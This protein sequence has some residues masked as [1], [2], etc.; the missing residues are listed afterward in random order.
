MT[1]RLRVGNHPL[2]S[3]RNGPWQPAS[4][5]GKRR[6]RQHDRWLWRK[7]SAYLETSSPL[8]VFEN[9]AGIGS[10]GNSVVYLR[11]Q[12]TPI[13]EF[14]IGKQS[15]LLTSAVTLKRWLRSPAGLYT[16]LCRDAPHRRDRIF[17]IAHSQRSGGASDRRQGAWVSVDGHLFGLCRNGRKMQT[18]LADQVKMLPT[19]NSAGEIGT[20]A[21]GVP[22]WLGVVSVSY[23][24]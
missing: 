22:H 13:K 20:Q 24:H 17:I 12:R 10:L 3:R 19:P 15:N 9:P 11:W 6:G 1:G 4:S 5:A 8:A 23:Q 18:R 21:H 7:L 16:S 14:A 2:V